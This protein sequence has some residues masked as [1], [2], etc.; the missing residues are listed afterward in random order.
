MNP[1][2]ERHICK[3]FFKTKV[4]FLFIFYHAGGV[5]ELNV[6][7]EV[8]DCFQEQAAWTCGKDVTYQSGG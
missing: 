2:E 1:T 6:S 5:G 8:G 7:F 4:F 3:P